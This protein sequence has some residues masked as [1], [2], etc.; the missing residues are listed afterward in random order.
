MSLFDSEKDSFFCNKLL[1]HSDTFI[2]KVIMHRYPYLY[3]H[4]KSN[5]ALVHKF[6]SFDVQVINNSNK[7][8]CDLEC[9]EVS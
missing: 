4:S 6:D 5:N 9:F 1:Y 7:Y 2:L 8:P 3:F